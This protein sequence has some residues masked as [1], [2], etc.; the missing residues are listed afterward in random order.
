VG[1]PALGA[2]RERVS[3]DRADFTNVVRALTKL[4]GEPEL[5]EPRDPFEAIVWENAA[6]LVD[7]AHRAAVFE[8][9]NAQI[10]VSPA[11]LLRAG[12]GKI[13]AVIA[14]GGGMRPAGRAAK[15]VRCAEIAMALAG[16]DLPSALRKLDG[17]GARRLLRRFPGI[18][19]PGADKILLLA[20]LSDE[21][22]VDSNGLRVLTRLGAVEEA[23]AYAATYRRAARFLAGVTAASGARRARYFGL[24]RTH[25]RTL[26]KRAAPRCQECP[27]EQLCPKKGVPFSAG[28]SWGRRL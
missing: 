4:Y 24:L 26:C 19:E 14:S 28:A 16:G 11:S 18:G 10:G 7:D 3:V 8:R 27:L 22:A 6:Y 23:D 2:R 12:P 25:G 9:L 17:P 15:V 21:P 1:P 5:L 20:G 13:E